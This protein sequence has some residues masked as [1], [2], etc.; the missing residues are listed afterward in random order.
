M[1]QLNNFIPMLSWVPQIF[2]LNFLWIYSG[3]NKGD[4]IGFL[5]NEGI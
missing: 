4:K 5:E 3:G 1:T 2:M